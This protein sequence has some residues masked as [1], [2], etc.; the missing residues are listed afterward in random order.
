MG[1]KNGL[2]YQQTRMSQSSGISALQCELLSPKGNQ[3]GESLQ[4]QSHQ[5]PVT[6]SGE[7][8]GAQNVKNT[9]YWPQGS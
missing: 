3:E 2:P 6:T 8:K 4:S 7:P 1:L 5:I 9:G